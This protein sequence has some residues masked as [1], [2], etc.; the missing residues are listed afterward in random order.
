MGAPMSATSVATSAVTTL[1]CGLLEVVDAVFVAV[2]QV[3]NIMSLLLR[4]AFSNKEQPKPSVVI[5]GASFAGLWAQRALSDN[6]NVTLVDLKDFFEVRP[7]TRQTRLAPCAPHP[8]DPPRRRIR[9]TL[10]A[11]CA[12]LWSRRTCV[13]SPSRCRRAGAARSS[14]RS[15]TSRLPS[16]RSATPPARRAPSRST[17]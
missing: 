1:A 16:S 15:S 5:V 17:I 12:S 11:C 4:A 10:L 14:P 7:P 13:A 8:A 2:A 3:Y 6:F 9:S